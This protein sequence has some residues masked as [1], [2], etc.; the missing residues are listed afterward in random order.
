L[1]WSSQHRAAA[2]ALT[3]S[4]RHQLNRRVFLPASSRCKINPT[5]NGKSKTRINAVMLMTAPLLSLGD[6][7]T[8]KSIC[9]VARH[10]EMRS[11]ARISQICPALVGGHR[12]RAPYRYRH[13]ALCSKSPS[14]KQNGKS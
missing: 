12:R 1:D 5:A 9:T 11:V 6:I 14:A 8:K 10:K 4:L 7:E 3:R 2:I 13:A